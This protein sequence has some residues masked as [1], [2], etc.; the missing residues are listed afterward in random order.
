MP[1]SKESTMKRLDKVE[2]D[3]SDIKGAIVQITT[4]LVQ[5]AELA[6]ANFKIVHQRIDA[7]NDSL[8]NRIDGVTTRL[9]AV[10]D[11][12]DRLIEVTIKERTLGIER[13]LEF[14]RRLTRLENRLEN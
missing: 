3:V 9:D 1:Q 6:D 5:Q 14:E 4:I 12:L 13:L 7:L 2:H 8:S 11:R 10:T